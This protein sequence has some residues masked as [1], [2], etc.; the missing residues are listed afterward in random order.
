MLFPTF[1]QHLI[2]SFIDTVYEYD[3]DG[4]VKFHWEKT[5]TPHDI[6]LL[7]LYGKTF[8]QTR[9][10]RLKSEKE[11]EKGKLKSQLING[12]EWAPFL[13]MRT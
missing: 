7:T 8:E 6:G 9:Q 5:G 13:M 3:K 1:A 2:D 11:G 10:L 12:E 4:K